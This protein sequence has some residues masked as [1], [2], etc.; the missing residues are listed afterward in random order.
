MVKKFNIVLIRLFLFS[1]LFIWHLPRRIF[2]RQNSPCIIH[3]LSM[4]SPWR[5]F[6][7]RILHEFFQGRIALSMLDSSW[8][9]P[10]EKLR[11]HEHSDFKTM[12]H[13]KAAKVSF[14]PKFGQQWSAYLTEQKFSQHTVMISYFKMYS[15]LEHKKLLYIFQ[16]IKYLKYLRLKR[17]H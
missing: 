2:P 13:W 12:S 3:E 14:N 15:T 11:R 17:G 9:M 5:I 6:Q 16:F 10:D 7:G 4:K 8:Q 1:K